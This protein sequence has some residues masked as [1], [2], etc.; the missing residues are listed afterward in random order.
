MIVLWDVTDIHPLGPTSGACFLK[1]TVGSGHFPIKGKVV[2]D[3]WNL[4]L[5]KMVPWLPGFVSQPELT[6]P[7]ACSLCPCVQIDTQGIYQLQVQCT[8]PHV[9]SGGNLRLTPNRVR[10]H[11]RDSVKIN[12]HNEEI[13]DS[14]MPQSFPSLRVIFMSFHH[15]WSSQCHSSWFMEHGLSPCSNY[16]LPLNVLNV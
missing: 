12:Q 15:E 6:V 2:S 8:E 16:L 9:K 11:F 7:P 13:S 5:F 4:F 14:L 3:F 10:E 1:N